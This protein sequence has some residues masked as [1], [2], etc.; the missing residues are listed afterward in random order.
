[1]NISFI[2]QQMV[3][4]NLDS[5]IYTDALPMPLGNSIFKFLMIDSEGNESDIVTCQYSCIPETNYDTEQA[6]FILKQNLAA[7]GKLFDPGFSGEQKIYAI[8]SAITKDGL[9]YYLIYE[10]SQSDNG[11]DKDRRY[12]CFSS[13][14]CDHFQSVCIIRWICFILGIL[15]DMYCVF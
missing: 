1:M 13:F 4:P 10:Y 2:I 9:V 8:D 7:Q 3:T 5:N 6:I 12:F 11:Y 15:M 14:G